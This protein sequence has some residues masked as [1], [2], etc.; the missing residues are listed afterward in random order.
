MAWQI[1]RK[2]KLLNSD[3]KKTFLNNHDNACWVAATKSI[4]T[5]K[6]MK[7]NLSKKISN[8]INKFKNSNKSNR[9]LLDVADLLSLL[10]TLKEA[11]ITV[12]SKIIVWSNKT[13]F[14]FIFIAWSLGRL[15]NFETTDLLSNKHEIR[16]SL[17]KTV[18]KRK[19]QFEFFDYIA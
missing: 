1:E 9:T 17:V 4:I 12:K 8:K 6:A 14:K 11:L 3:F 7:H 10:Q 18:Y 19:A 2:Q 16:R 15:N 5:N 13:P